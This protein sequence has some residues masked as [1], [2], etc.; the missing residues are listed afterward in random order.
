MR[1]RLYSIK[2]DIKEIYKIV[3]AMLFIKPFLL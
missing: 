2:P 3:E 1:I